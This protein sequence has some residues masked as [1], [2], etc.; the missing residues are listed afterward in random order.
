MKE[1]ERGRELLHQGDHRQQPEQPVRRHVPG[2]KFIAE[3]V[4][5]CEK[6][7]ST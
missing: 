4:E 1:I 7:G 3:L 2:E 6:K 5:F